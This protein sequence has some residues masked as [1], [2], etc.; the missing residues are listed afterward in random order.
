MSG[1]GVTL[2]VGWCGGCIQP[3]IGMFQLQEWLYDNE[4][5]LKINFIAFNYTYEHGEH[6][7]AILRLV[8]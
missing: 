7:T 4:S 2:G 3:L 1:S 5:V 6:K 8:Y